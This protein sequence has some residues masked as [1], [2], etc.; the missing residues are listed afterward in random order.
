MIKWHKQLQAASNPV[1][2]PVGSD[3]YSL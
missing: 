2:T 3:D 1:A